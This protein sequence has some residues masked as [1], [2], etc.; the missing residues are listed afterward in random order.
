MG[1]WL[2]PIQRCHKSARQAIQKRDIQPKLSPLPALGPTRAAIGTPF[3]SARSSARMKGYARTF[4]RDLSEADTHWL[5]HVADRL[6]GGPRDHA[7]LDVAVEQSD[8]GSGEHVRTRVAVRR[9][10]HWVPRIVVVDETICGSPAQD[11]GSMK[12]GRFPNP[13]DPSGSLHNLSSTF[14]ISGSEA[15]SL[16]N[17]F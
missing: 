9:W 14:R 2:L 7:R 13:D 3:H 6:G 1:H 10:H 17:S 15:E 16:E 12:F 11:N 5:P 4:G 8:P